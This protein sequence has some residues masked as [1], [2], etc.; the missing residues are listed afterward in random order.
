L[1]SLQLTDVIVPVAA[2]SLQSFKFLALA[3]SPLA[4]LSRT[5]CRTLSLAFFCC[6]PNPF[7]WATRSRSIDPHEGRAEEIQTRATIIRTW[8]GRYVVV[9]NADLFTRSVIVNTAG[10]S[11]RW[12]YNFDVR[13][14]RPLDEIRS[15]IADAVRR[16]P[17]VL[18]NPSPDVF[19]ADLTPDVVKLR[20]L[21]S[22][23]EARQQHMLVS[24]DQVLTAITN[25][26]DRLQ[27]QSQRAA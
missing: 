7:A 18:F 11:R 1:W 17:G 10:Q 24:Y 12:E 20:V 16:A 25:A 15:A 3:A 14:L 22:T 4:F 13:K 19:L 8:D 26:L 27:S 21:W 9:P 2:E 23:R 5:S 6:G